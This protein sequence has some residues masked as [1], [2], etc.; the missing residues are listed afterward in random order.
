MANALGRFT[1][2]T[3][4][5]SMPV[6]E[7][8][9]LFDERDL[10]LYSLAGMTDGELADL[11]RELAL[12][13]ERPP[14]DF[15]TK[16][17]ISNLKLALSNRCPS[18]CAY[19]FRSTL[20]MPR[21]R[22]RL[23]RDLLESMVHGFGRD[24]KSYTVTFNLTSEPLADLDQLEELTKLRDEYAD[25][26]G[27]SIEIYICTSATVQAPE[28]LEALAAASGGRLAVSID[29]PEEAHDRFRR[30]LAGRGTY[31]RVRA[32]VEWGKARGMKL[33]AQSVLDARFPEPQT[34]SRTIFSAWDSTPSA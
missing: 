31:D 30:D 22:A 6:G 13:V 7:G 21:P 17:R 28:A 33:E 27:K 18:D 23:V 29:G 25:E 12:A 20:P 15:R 11:E 8:S 34:W 32:L 16:T 26:T 2:T 1:D 5:R 24:A 9:W 10:G 14:V 4:F 19:C 3:R